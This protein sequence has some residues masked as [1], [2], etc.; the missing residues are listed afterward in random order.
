MRA[1][2]HGFR[3]LGTSVRSS[4]KEGWPQFWRSESTTWCQFPSW[5]SGDG[6]QLCNRTL[7][8]HTLFLS[9]S[10]G[11]IIRCWSVWSS[12]VNLAHTQFESSWEHFL[13]ART[14]PCCYS[15]STAT[16]A[17]PHRKTAH[18]RNLQAACWWLLFSR[19]KSN[20]TFYVDRKTEVFIQEW[21]A[22]YAKW[23]THPLQAEA[24]T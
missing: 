6:K 10:R 14:N 18:K 22:I 9:S 23:G 13:G 24:L 16:L 19:G 8:W 5:Y 11:L 17:F 2:C 20:T 7:C 15:F 12:C 21:I 4:I 3:H 1:Q